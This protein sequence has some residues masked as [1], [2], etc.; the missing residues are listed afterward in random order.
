[1]TIS[2]FTKSH[3]K[4]IKINMLINI[5]QYLERGLT[6]VGSIEWFS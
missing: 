5:H 4:G 1:M 3:L 6:R 2:S